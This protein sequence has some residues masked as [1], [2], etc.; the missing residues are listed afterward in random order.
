LGGKFDALAIGTS[1]PADV[2]KPEMAVAI[3]LAK[4]TA[5]KLALVKSARR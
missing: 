2:D 4:Y 5:A 3:V 1:T